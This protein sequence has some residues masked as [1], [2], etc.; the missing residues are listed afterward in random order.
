MPSLRYAVIALKQKEVEQVITKME[1]LKAALPADQKAK[2]LQLGDLMTWFKENG[3]A[4]YGKTNE[5]W[6]PFN[7]QT[8]DELINESAGYSRQTNLIEKFNLL[9]ENYDV[10]DPI[11]VYFIDVFALFLDKYNK[12]ADKMDYHLAKENQCCLIIPYKWPDAIQDTVLGTYAK[13]LRMVYGAYLQ[14]KL[15]R[16]AMRVEDLKNFRNFIVNTLG[17]EDRPS[18]AAEAQIKQKLP[19]KSTTLPG[20]ENE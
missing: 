11:R 20:R 7:G 2:A 13:T 5:E 1:G 15:H 12:L 6:K 17:E 16:I 4:F 19:Q 8:I 9:E 18:D 10:V 3:D 14:G